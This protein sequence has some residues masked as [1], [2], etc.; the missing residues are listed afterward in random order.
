MDEVVVQ[1]R[2]DL[3]GLTGRIRLQMQEA[4]NRVAIGL[5]AGLQ[6]TPVSLEMPG[7]TF[8]HTFDADN[9]WTVE[10]AR[11][12]WNL[13]VLKNGFRDVAETIGG[14]LEEVQKVLA[15]WALHPKMRRGK[16]LSRSDYDNAV[17]VSVDKFHHKPLPQ[18][19]KYFKDE[20]CFELQSEYQRQLLSLNAARNCLVHREGRIGPDDAKDGKALVVEW[21]AMALFVA[22]ANGE[23]EI[24]LP[25]RSDDAD[26]THRLQR[27]H[28]S[29]EF[30]LGTQLTVSAQ[31]FEEITWSLFLFAHSTAEQMSKYAVEKGIMT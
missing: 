7:V 28:R 13:W 4:T 18:K 25:Y 19:F 6:I 3:D 12:S 21:Y 26:A 24:Q 31:E 9:P 20:Y 14:A 10:Q 22:D 30:P 8:A 23:R 27:V 5:N 11:D 29:K 2:V 1:V 17:I 16:P 15:I